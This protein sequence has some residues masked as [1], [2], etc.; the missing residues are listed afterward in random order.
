MRFT[1]NH[2]GLNWP[3]SMQ[4]FFRLAVLAPV[5]LALTAGT[6]QATDKKFE[7]IL[8]WGTDG[9]KPEDKELKD[10]DEQLKHKF[11]KFFKWQNYYE[12]K[13]VP[14][15]LKA[16]ETP[17]TV[18]VSDKCSVVMAYTEKEGMEVELI[19]EGKS[20]HKTKQAM[21]LTDHLVLAG[22]DINATAWFVVIQPK[23]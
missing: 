17:K 11:R 22:P 14:I 2:S 4:K 9:G 18:K 13:R 16:G 20:I 15:T 23:N 21:P 19:G 1:E 3:A 6:V 12:V 8:I 5:F 7:A 10:V